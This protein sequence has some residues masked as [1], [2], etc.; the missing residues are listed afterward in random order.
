MNQA[1]HQNSIDWAEH[2]AS[3]QRSE[4]SGKAY[5]A[6]HNLNYDQFGYYKRKFSATSRSQKAKDSG[7]VIAKLDASQSTKASSLSLVLPS[8]IRIEGIDDGNLSAC[9]GLLGR[10]S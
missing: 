2:I 4:L 1:T 9:L 5:C 7:F 10:L 8:G 6:K 3:H